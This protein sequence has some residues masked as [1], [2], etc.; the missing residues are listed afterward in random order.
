MILLTLALIYFL[1]MDPVGHVKGIVERLEGIPAKRTRFIIARELLFALVFMLIFDWF[2]EY[3]ISFLHISESS[4]YL[5]SGV[6]LFLAALKIL[7]PHPEEN[8]IQKDREEPFLVPL[9]IPMIA[10]PALLATI[11]LYAETEANPYTTIIAI[12]FAWLLASP[13]LLYSKQILS[14]VGTSGL[15]ACEKLMGMVL[16]LI[17]IQR[18]MDGIHL[19]I[20]NTK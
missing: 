10:G 6:V 17:S 19:F 12:L 3:I 15:T 2:G 14:Y 7:F 13:I 5:A 9:A 8:S 20:Q 1:I 18:F 11:M 16:V 4:I